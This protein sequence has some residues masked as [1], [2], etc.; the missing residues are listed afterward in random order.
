MKRGEKYPI[1]SGEI[2][3]ILTFKKICFGVR[4]FKASFIGIIY[5]MSDIIR[6]FPS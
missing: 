5:K 2:S 1:K 3:C 4:I 6:L